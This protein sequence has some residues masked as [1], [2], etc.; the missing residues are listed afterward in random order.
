MGEREGAYRTLNAVAVVAGMI[1]WIWYTV[2]KCSYPARK[3]P[4]PLNHIILSFWRTPS[5]TNSV[6]VF[7]ADSN[8]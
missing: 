6:I 5:S 2:I 7:V 8:F 4:L 3:P 1:F